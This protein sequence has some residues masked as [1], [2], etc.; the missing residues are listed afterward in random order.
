L[1]GLQSEG[2]RQEAAAIDAISLT[3][4]A[5]QLRRDIDR[6]E[7]YR[8]ALTTLESISRDDVELEAV[9]KRL[10][11]DADAGVASLAELVFS[12]DATAVAIL[13]NA[14][15]DAEST[16]VDQILDRARRVVRV[17]RVGTDLPPDS[18][19]GRLSRVEFRLREGD[20]AGAVAILDL[21]E[22]GAAEAARSWVVRA[23]SYVEIGAALETIEAQ[24]LARLRTAGG[25]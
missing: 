22:G 13:D 17:R 20:V 16:I 3:L 1:A 12:F 21:L 9:V 2:A 19:D 6:G 7:P 23:K 24:A 18:I 5:S 15:E 25:S 11:L 4:A 10:S 14:P 8:D